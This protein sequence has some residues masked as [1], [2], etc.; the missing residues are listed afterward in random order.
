MEQPISVEDIP[1]C[2]MNFIK[3][4]LD[5]DK[6]TNIV[7]K[8]DYLSDIWSEDWL[9]TRKGKRLKA[10]ESYDF[11]LR[12][13]STYAS[14]LKPD[15]KPPMDNSHNLELVAGQIVTAHHP[16]ITAKFAGAFRCFTHALK[17]SLKEK[18][19]I[20]DGVNS[21]QMNG[22]WNTLYDEDAYYQLLEIDM[23]KYDKSQGE[24]I[25][26][27]TCYIL[28]LFKMPD[29]IIKEWKDCHIINRLVFHKIGV[30]MKVKYQRRSG[31][32]FTFIGNTLVLMVILS[33]VY[34]LNDK[35][36][37]G[38]IFGGD[39][40]LILFSSTNLLLDKTDNISALFNIV[41]KI[42][43]H[44][45]CAKFA[46][47]FEIYVEGAYMFVRDPIKSIIRLGRHDMF[48]KQHVKEYYVSFCD[49]HKELKNLHVREELAKATYNRYM[50]KFKIANYYAVVT[51]I[52]F[53]TS[54][55]YDEQKFMN[56]YQ[57]PK[58]IWERKLPE[59]LKEET[60][61]SIEDLID[62]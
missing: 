9:S 17:Y 2:A 35:N 37:K 7:N 29:H 12:N 30:S 43:K 11:A 27:I 34:D 46:S 4:F 23:A 60:L 13:P 41:A 6:F 38:G 25:L 36:C 15:L 61:V 1:N 53:L 31:D 62:F 20:N 18:W 39:D 57:A 33:F 3:T 58:A 32:I 26:E 5:E 47:K 54:L 16:M 42:E 8:L 40:S 14:H 48:C 19:L 22:F 44:F 21:D 56:L 52:N 59:Y 50:H 10:L 55:L 49:G 28:K 51:I 45:D 24:R